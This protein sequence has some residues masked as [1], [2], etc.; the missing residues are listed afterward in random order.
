M[1]FLVSN[2]KEIIEQQISSLRESDFDPCSAYG[3]VIDN[4][5]QANAKN[6]KVEFNYLT[7]RRSEKRQSEKLESISFGDDGDGMDPQTIEDCLGFGF[8]TR[9]NDRKGIGRFG[10]GLT[11]AFLNQ[12]LKCEV[13][14]KQKNKDWYYTFSDIRPSNKQKNLIPKPVK[15]KPPKDLLSLIGKNSGTLVVWKEHDKQ[16]FKSSQLIE[17]FK[18]W[19]GRTYRKFIDRGVKISING[20]E[21]KTIDPLY[22]KLKNSKFPKDPTSEVVFNESIEWPI[23]R[24]KAKK[25]G[26]MGKIFVK[27]TFLPVKLRKGKGDK[28]KQFADLMSERNLGE[29]NAGLSIIRNDREVFYGVPYP[30]VKNLAFKNEDRFIGFEV[31]FNAKFDKQ[32][33][34]KN[35]KRGALPVAELKQIISDKVKGVIQNL[36]P[37]IHHQWESYESQQEIKKREK[38]IFTGHEDAEDVLKKQVKTKDP[39]TEKKDKKELDNKVTDEILDERH[40]RQRALWEARFKA[41]P[42]TILDSE[43]K[44]NE[45][46]QLGYTKDGAVMKYNLNHPLHV[47]ITKLINAMEN[48]KDAE[49][50]KEKAK[51]LKA[52]IDLVLISYCKSE[53]QVDPDDKV[54]NVFDFLEELRNNW[55]NYLKRYIRDL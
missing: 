41:Q 33:T 15:Q 43:W 35:I 19:C 48:E 21:L 12:C 13:Y 44:G 8:S 37:K 16:D 32:F 24:D 4:S 18:I 31:N 10:V 38:G 1:G 29:D 7:K 40:R 47:E 34:V 27:L 45:F 25:E 49:K 3:E 42:Y 22:I 17:E 26:E 36:R 54:T 9:Y 5:I 55:G 28:H 11:L 30:W 53:K 2:V 23:D 50:M 20:E 39:L 52:I 6:I 14:S 51:R 46:V